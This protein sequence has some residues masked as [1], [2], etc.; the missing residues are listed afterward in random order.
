MLCYQ[1]TKPYMHFYTSS[2]MLHA[3]MLHKK[4]YGYFLLTMESLLL[5]LKKVGTERDFFS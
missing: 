2:S 1:A 4:G 5:G 3:Q